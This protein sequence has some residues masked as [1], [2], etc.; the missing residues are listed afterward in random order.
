VK[1]TAAVVQ[2]AGEDFQ[3]SEVEI[4]E[5]R[6]NEVIVK[7]AASGICRTDVGARYGN[8]QIPFPA[9][10]GHEGAGVVE[11]VGA[12]V[13][14]VAPGDHVVMTFNTC[15]GCPNCQQGFPTYCNNGFP[16]NLMGSRL[17]GSSAYQ[18]DGKRISGHFFGQSSFATFSICTERN[19]V[20]I[21]AGFPLGDRGTPGLR[22]TNRR[23]RDTQYPERTP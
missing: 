14:K 7:L 18:R 1:A 15:G 13:T 3:L 16:L 5:P 4:G 23:R 21:P 11:A 17:D 22:N 8:Y 10:F 2:Q 19:V 20:K 12:N 9:I 6:H